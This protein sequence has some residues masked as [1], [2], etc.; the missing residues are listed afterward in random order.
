MTY[1]D[2]VN[3]CTDN[4]QLALW[5]LLIWSLCAI[6]YGLYMERK[7]R[8]SLPDNFQLVGSS[9]RSMIGVIRAH[10]A[11][12]QAL[13]RR[14]RPYEP[15]RCRYCNSENEPKAETCRNCGALMYERN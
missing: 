13:M 7:R 8:R 4:F 3:W 15:P 1:T 12:H 6:G 14:A 10:E 11:A 5:L 2:L 9:V